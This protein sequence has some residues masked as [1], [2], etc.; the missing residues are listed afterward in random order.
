MNKHLLEILICPHCKGK[1][2]YQSKEKTLICK[3]EKLAFTIKEGIPVMLY[4]EAQNL[5]EPTSV[6]D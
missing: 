3:G 1:L 2:T 5:N 4:T 6:E